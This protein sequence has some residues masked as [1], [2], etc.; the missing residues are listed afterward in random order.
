MKKYYPC[1]DLFKFIF[2]L[3]VICV[4]V[5]PF[6]DVNSTLNFIIS[7]LLASFAVPFYFLVSGYLSGDGSFRH[8]VKKPLFL[9][10]LNMCLYLFISHFWELSF[11]HVLQS[12]I[13]T[14]GYY[15]LWY[16]VVL[17][18]CMIFYTVLLK[19]IPSQYCIAFCFITYLSGCLFRTYFKIDNL[20]FLFI[21]RFLSIG[22]P[23]FYY[24]VWIRKKHKEKKFSS[25]GRYNLF[26]FLLWIIEVL[27]LM[28]KGNSVGYTLLFS[29]FPVIAIIFSYTIY[30]SDKI[31]INFAPTL[32]KMS[33]II[34]CIHPAILW[35]LR[36]VCQKFNFEKLNSF[37]EFI[38]VTIISIFVSQIYCVANKKFEIIKCKGKSFK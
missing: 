11:L 27:I 35:F 18:Y 29:S 14:G 31:K 16:L 15:H 1:I 26:F 34:Y 33:M 30:L 37:V 25:L 19:K 32:G 3:L 10:L 36:A 22:L 5:N 13:L 4:H 9:C 38:F 28:E 12:I 2:S 23:F 20:V 24:G 6:L 7:G 21:F 17:I 8:I